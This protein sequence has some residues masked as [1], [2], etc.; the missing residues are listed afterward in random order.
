MK[1]LEWEGWFTNVK[2]YTF[3]IETYMNLFPCTDY[4]NN[5]TNEIDTGDSESETYALFKSLWQRVTVLKFFIEHL[6]HIDKVLYIRCITLWNFFDQSFDIKKEQYFSKLT[7]FI[8]SI[9]NTM[10][11]KYLT[12]CKG[13]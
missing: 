9:S 3:L 7:K 6:C 4:N 11:K 12:Q 2:K 8:K 10:N 13:N 1:V 5:Q